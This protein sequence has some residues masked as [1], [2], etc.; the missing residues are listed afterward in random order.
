MHNACRAR[1]ALGIGFRIAAAPPAPRRRWLSSRM[2]CSPAGLAPPGCGR[3]VRYR[4]IGC[5]GALRGLATLQHIELFR[6]LLDRAQGQ[7]IRERGDVDRAFDGIDR[8]LEGDHDLRPGLRRGA[9]GIADKVSRV[10]MAPSARLTSPFTARSTSGVPNIGLLS[11]RTWPPS[12]LTPASARR[13]ASAPPASAELILSPT[14]AASIGMPRSTARM[15]VSNAAG[16]SRANR[17]AAERDSALFLPRHRP[18]R[19]GSFR[20]LRP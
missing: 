5:G 20:S 12:M 17:P 4:R 3:T 6:L 11:I 15:R 1:S 18:A 8:S 9:A 7:P 2:N 14:L 16:L 19:S 13:M 10:S